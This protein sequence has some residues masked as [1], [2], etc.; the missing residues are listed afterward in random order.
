[1]I[2]IFPAIALMHRS[3][4]EK[5]GDEMDSDS[6]PKTIAYVGAKIEPDIRSGKTLRKKSKSVSFSFKL[7]F[8]FRQQFKLQALRRNMAMTD[9]LV[10]I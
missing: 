5:Q 7:P 8:E 6:V 3:T 9:L 1:M 10:L 4:L 2:F